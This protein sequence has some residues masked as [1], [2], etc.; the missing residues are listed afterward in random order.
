MKKYRVREGSIAD[1]FRYGAVGLMFG[2]LC[3][4]VMNSTVPF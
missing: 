1:Y 2:V 3:G 4:I